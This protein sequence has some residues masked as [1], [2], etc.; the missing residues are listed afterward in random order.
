MVRVSFGYFSLLDS[1]SAPIGDVIIA[2]D[3]VLLQRSPEAAIHDLSYVAIWSAAR[4]DAIERELD[5]LA[6]TGGSVVDSRTPEVR[7][8]LRAISP[9]A[10]PVFIRG[11]QCSRTFA[12]RRLKAAL[13]TSDATLTR[14]A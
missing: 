13:R 4:R 12:R 1:H 3:H 11:G 14:T 6:R 9:T 7:T 8:I 10:T 5:I 2:P